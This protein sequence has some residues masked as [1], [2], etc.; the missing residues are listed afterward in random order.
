MVSKYNKFCR[1]YALFC[2]NWVNIGRAYN[3]NWHVMGDDTE[4]DGTQE[5]GVTGM[6][7][8]LGLIQRHTIN[9]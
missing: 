3:R 6:F 4:E 8:I 7:T 2:V 1:K 5:A 9:K